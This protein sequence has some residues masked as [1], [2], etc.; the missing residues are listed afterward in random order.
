MAAALN[1][2]ARNLTFENRS[3]RNLYKL[4]GIAPKLRDKVFSY[5]ILAAFIVYFVIPISSSVIYFG[6]IAT[7]QYESEIRFIVR[8][9]VPL[10]TRDR[11]ASGN[12]ET[13]GKNS[14]GHG[15]HP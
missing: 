11:Y 12:A 6:F 13:E 2:Y 9:S 7:P 15:G 8:S 1:S 4:A 14:P 10:L 3:R 5:L